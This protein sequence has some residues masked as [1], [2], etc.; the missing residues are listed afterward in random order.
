MTFMF[1]KP[2]T[3]YR[4]MGEKVYNFDP[5]KDYWYKPLSQSIEPEYSK[6]AKRKEWTTLFGYA[7]QLLGV[8]PDAPK[9]LNYIYN[10][11]VKLMGDEYA[12]FATT[13][14][15]ERKPITPQGGQGQQ[16]LAGGGGMPTSNQNMVPMS[17][18]EMDTRGTV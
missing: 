3:A 17:G 9:M 14:L 10:E 1:A 7:A 4:L 5:S 2:E 18:A 13:F 12:N 8:H 15:D 6:A 11:F 16:M